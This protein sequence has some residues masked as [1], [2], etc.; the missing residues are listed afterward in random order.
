V[1]A[2]GHPGKL[3]IMDAFPGCP[4]LL[5]ALNVK[6]AAS[7]FKLA[8]PG[9]SRFGDRQRSSTA[10][11]R[12]AEIGRNRRAR[13]RCK[14]TDHP[15]RYGTMPL[16]LLGIAGYPGQAGAANRVA[17]SAKVPVSSR[18]PEPGNPESRTPA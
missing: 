15:P 1:R 11:S 8:I 6:Q 16:I 4:L 3:P 17:A 10:A 14:I 5:C 2:R 9:V 12:T 18:L 7:V 13:P